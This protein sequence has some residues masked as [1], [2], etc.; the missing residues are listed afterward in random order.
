V[1]KSEAKI[2]PDHPGTL[3]AMYQLGDVY[4]RAGQPDKA[5]LLLERALARY[6]VKV[7]DGHADTV[8]TLAALGDACAKA[9][10]LDKAL[11]LLEEA[12]AK[13]E[14]KM[15]PDHQDTLLAMNGLAALYLAR[16]ECGRAGPLFA[17][18]VEGYERKF[19]AGHPDTLAVKRDAELA[20][21]LRA[22]GDAYQQALGAKGAD[23][24]AALSARQAFAAALREG[25][26][27]GGA[28]HH[29]QAVLDARRRLAGADH[30]DTLACQIELGVTRLAQKRYAEAE[31]LLVQGYEGL[32]AAAAKD[33][34]ASAPGSAGSAR[35]REAQERLAQLYEAWDKKDLAAQWRAKL[36]GRDAG[37]GKR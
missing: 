12:L 13:T 28:A 25:G 4:V 30:P 31:P 27:A 29:F 32:R 20:R 9:G 37:G 14:A 17:R 5:E 36:P 8:A 35:L 7:G 24:P 34:A 6:R 15:G 10:K 33:P 22:A 21:Q 23:D 11:P 26:L 19:G 1:A 3:S 16:G 18:A 2:G